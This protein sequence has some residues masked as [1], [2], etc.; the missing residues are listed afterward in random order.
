MNEYMKND[1]AKHTI[2]PLTKFGL[3]QITRQRVRQATR[4]ETEEV[5]PTCHGKGQVQPTLFF[6]D[7]VEKMVNQLTNEEGVK[8]FS[9]H[10]HPFVAAY[11]TKKKGFLGAVSYTQLLFTLLFIDGN[12]AGVKCAMAELGLLDENLRLPLVEM[13]SPNR[14]AMIQLISDLRSDKFL[15]E[16][17]E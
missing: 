5:C 6:T 15:N 12:P 8:K 3:M 1:R 7:E 17:I 14:E 2:L 4:I 9:I 10:L 13:Q 16:C 11:L